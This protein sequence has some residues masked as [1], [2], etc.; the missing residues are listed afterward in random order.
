MIR[1]RLKNG[2]SFEDLEGR[3]RNCILGYNNSYQIKQMLNEFISSN[4]EWEKLYVHLSDNLDDLI[5]GCPFKLQSIVSAIELKIK[6]ITGSGTNKKRTL[7]KEIIPNLRKVFNYKKFSDEKDKWGAYA[8][9]EYLQCSVC[10]YCNRNFTTFI[11]KLTRPQLDHFFSQSEYPYL[12]LSLYNLIPSCSICNGPALKRQQKFSL[13]SNIHPYISDFEDKMRFTLSPIN[14][15]T[16]EFII[17]H[18]NSDEG[19]FNIDFEVG[20]PMT[21][22]RK[23]KI[24]NNIRIFALK[25]LYNTHKGYAK[26]ILRK[27]TIYKPEIMDQLF[28]E[29]GLTSFEDRYTILYGNFWKNEDFGLRP[30]S[31][32]SRDIYLYC[33]PDDQN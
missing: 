4:H 29:V 7:K 21:P 13:S 27:N 1:I 2:K 26:E 32:F 30:L 33:H 23:Q 19:D 6:N 24:E 20:K 16:R 8:L 10:P 12:A 31:K 25:E 15:K 14:G 11:N 5:V 22:K 9:T 17:S 28:Q 3:H 18:F